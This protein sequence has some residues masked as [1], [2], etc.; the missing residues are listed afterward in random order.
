M[1]SEGD[2]IPPTERAKGN[3]P[4][5]KHV[6]QGCHAA[7]GKRK[8]R[9]ALTRAKDGGNRRPGNRVPTP[10]EKSGGP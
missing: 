9:H 6:L 8:E 7:D 2:W 10:D 1:V 4:P 5:R 3:D